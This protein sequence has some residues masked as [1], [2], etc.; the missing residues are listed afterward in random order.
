[1]NK[2]RAAAGSAGKVEDL[3]PKDTTAFV[4]HR[5]SKNAGSRY[6]LLQ[7]VAKKKYRQAMIHKREL[8]E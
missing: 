3:P 8:R 7:I 4:T 2:K 6:L 5:S 1:M